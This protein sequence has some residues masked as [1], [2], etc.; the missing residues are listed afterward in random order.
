MSANDPKRTTNIK[1]M[2]DTLYKYM[3]H[4]YEHIDWY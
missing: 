3:L 2:C 1:L 4:M